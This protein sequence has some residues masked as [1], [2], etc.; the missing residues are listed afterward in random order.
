MRYK[1]ETLPYEGCEALELVVQ[2]G[3]GYPIPGSAQGQAGEGFK[4]PDVVKG[5]AVH[6]RQGVRMR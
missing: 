5:V 2:R 6:S 4:Q 1:V 3:C